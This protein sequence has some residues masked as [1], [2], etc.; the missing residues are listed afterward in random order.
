MTE[1]SRRA[2]VGTGAALGGLAI[3]SAAH[4]GTTVERWG[5]YEITLEG[6]KTAN[7][8]IDVTFG[9]IFS[10][11]GKTTH[12]P[13]FYDG[14]G[15]Y[16]AR[17]SPD[18][19]G[20]WQWTT[21]SNVRALNGKRGSFEATTPGKDNHGPVR[22]TK[23]GYHFA[24]ADGTPYRQIGTTSYSW[25]Q[26]SDDRCA[27]TLATLSASPFN[28]IRMCLFPNVAA[29]ATEP[30]VTTGPGPKD[31]DAKRFDPA[32]FR[33]YED[34]LIRLGT[35]GIQ[36]DIILFHP[37]NTARGFSDMAREDDER[38]LRYV[39]ARFSAYRHVWW[40]MANEF[41]A[42]KTKTTADWDH[43]FQVL[44]AADPHDRLRSIHNMNVYYDARQPWITHASV[45]N[46]AAVED[47]GRAQP[48][49]LFAQKAVI[50]DEVCYEGNSTRRWGQL[51][52]EEMVMRFW[53]GTIAGTYVGHSDTFSDPDQTDRSW[54]G[55]GGRLQ[56]TSSP[57]LAFLK[58]ILDAAPQPGIEPIDTTYD[59]HL[60]GKPF[61]YYLRYFGREAPTLWAL[62]LPGKHK[63]P[64]NSYRVDII[65]TWNMTITPIDGA[66]AMAVKD[67][68]SFHDPY[69]PT[70]ILPGK[71]WIAVRIVKV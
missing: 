42:V 30:F 27:E 71:P 6:R 67:D 38:Y 31:W 29:E 9:A 40:S 20:P 12:V 24:Y 1:P 32:Y 46:G 25:A 50:F 23:D 60:G 18:A 8:F 5:V 55:Q 54:L 4:A 26:Q 63:D 22:V 69:R 44:Q 53:W 49:R 10:Q 21:T 64:K 11:A 62:D 41:D 43:L 28:K 36:A 66:F 65:D 48:H 2:V 16:R 3:S 17:F 14:D 58:T 7:P 59:R 47:D 70:I 68:Y 61:E 34:G 52:G 51:S 57:R 15:V 33:R 39:A 56:G 35:L 37:Y 45:Q 13:G 19:T